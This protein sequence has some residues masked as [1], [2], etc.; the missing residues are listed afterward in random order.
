MSIKKVAKIT[1]NYIEYEL[2]QEL[3]RGTFGVVYKA[4]R[5][6]DGRY[7][8]IKILDAPVQDITEIHVMQGLRE[9]S[10]AGLF[11]WG[12]WEYLLEK[13][14]CLIMQ[15]IE[16]KNLRRYCAG[17]SDPRN[18]DMI[19]GLIVQIARA[20]HRLHT[21][22]P[23][24]VIHR[25][26]KPANILVDGNGRP[27]ILDFGVSRLIDTEKTSLSA[28]T[29]GTGTPHY[30]APEQLEGGKLSCRCDIWALGV[31]LFELLEGEPPFQGAT[32]HRINEA[33]LHQPVRW[34]N[35]SEPLLQKIVE[36]AL[37][38]REQERYTSAYELA[39]V[40]SKYLRDRFSGGQR[41]KWRGIKPQVYRRY[42][43]NISRCA[44]LSYPL[45]PPQ[46]L[47]IGSNKRP[48]EIW[49]GYRLPNGMNLRD[50]GGITVIEGEAVATMLVQ[51]SAQLARLGIK[52]AVPQA[53]D[54]YW[55][56]HGGNG[57]VLASNWCY[58][59]WS[60]TIP[61]ESVYLMLR[62][63]MR[64]DERE[65]WADNRPTLG[66]N[67][68]EWSKR[69]AME[70][71]LLQ[72]MANGELVLRNGDLDEVL[73]LCRQVMTLFWGRSN[74]L[75]RRAGQLLR[76]I[77]IDS[78]AHAPADTVVSLL[79][80]TPPLLKNSIAAHWQQRDRHQRIRNIWISAAANHRVPYMPD[81]RAWPAN[82]WRECWDDQAGLFDFTAMAWRRLTPASQYRYARSYQQWY[83]R[84]IGR[85]FEKKISKILEVVWQEKR[86]QVPLAIVL[87]LV[88][89]G[90]FWMGSPPEEN[91][92]FEN[93][94]CHCVTIDRPYWI[95]R[96][97]ITQEQWYAV[98]GELPWSGETFSRDHPQHAATYISWNDVQHKF[99]PRICQELGG[100]FRLPSEAQW[101]YACRAGSLARFYWGESEKNIDSY[102]WYRGNR[103]GRFAHQVALK[104][105]NAWNLFDMSGNVYE[106]CRDWYAD[107]N[108]EPCQNPSGPEH[109]SFR[110]IRGGFWDLAP[111][112]CRCACRYEGWPDY[113]VYG[114][115]FRIVAVSIL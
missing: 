73:A 58:G 78:G 61:A 88:P 45:I 8:A 57:T 84:R 22:Q 42:Q 104:A 10:I 87:A 110:V 106:W 108:R 5:L 102:A 52:P 18:V 107:Y 114:V 72:R 9:E 17:Q 7:V 3:G 98:T 54:I 46:V 37:A 33:I 93:E 70:R 112:C 79:I 55:N 38:K 32:V 95:G 94:Q 43:Q 39:C 62:T 76:L 53:K 56:R 28:N 34:K 4:R 16:G 25:D 40:L 51:A 69:V 23:E 29:I 50:L 97:P 14:L 105:P 15:Y 13:K 19:V 31:I 85:P 60:R 96:F 71:Q 82:L 27:Y 35:F 99:L 66:E 109:G 44:Q 24:A 68:T 77:K 92:R 80:D 1:I 111:R 47:V 101:E 74:R 36:K 115:G 100:D 21:V 30:R 6:S 65:K 59:A 11:D 75:R 26:L 20:M 63:V 91:G 89:P 41:F 12:H 83:A 113:R 67:L 90:R 103:K 49:L 81:G 86:K 64:H 48:T 2:E